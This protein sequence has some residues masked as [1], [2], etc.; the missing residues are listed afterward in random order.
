MQTSIV[1]MVVVFCSLLGAT[2]QI[3]FKQ[4]SDSNNIVRLG[5]GLLL[6]GSATILYVYMLRYGEL[7]MLYPIISLSYV[8]V[9]FFSVWLFNESLTWTKFTGVMLILGGV[10]AIWS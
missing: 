10:Y 2:G 6:Y 8:W 1:I 3:F 7:S 4:A 9:L 5:F